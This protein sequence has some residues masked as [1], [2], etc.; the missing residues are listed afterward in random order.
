MPTVFLGVLHH[1]RFDKFLNSLKQYALELRKK[2]PFQIHQSSLSFHNYDPDAILFNNCAVARLV[3]SIPNDEEVL[4]VEL[5][6][7]FTGIKKGQRDNPLSTP[8]KITDRFTWDEATKNFLGVMPTPGQPIVM[9]LMRHGIGTHNVGNVFTKHFTRDPFLHTTLGI[10]DAAQII[11]QDVFFQNVKTL[12]L[13]SSPLRRAIQ[14]LYAVIDEITKTKDQEWS[15]ET[16]SDRICILPCLR[17]LDS[18]NSSQVRLGHIAVENWSVLNSWEHTDFDSVFY[19]TMIENHYT[20]DKTHFRELLDLETKSIIMDWSLAQD[21]CREGQTFLNFL[22]DV[23]LQGSQLYEQP[24]D[25]QRDAPQRTKM[26]MLIEQYTECALRIIDINNGLLQNFIRESSL[27]HN[28]W[29][30]TAEGRR[31]SI[32]GIQRIIT[33]FTKR[34]SSTGWTT[35]STGDEKILHDLWQIERRSTIFWLNLLGASVIFPEHAQTDLPYRLTWNGSTQNLTG[36]WR[37]G[38][39]HPD[40]NGIQ[41]QVSDNQ[42]TPSFVLASG[43]S[44]S[45]K[46]FFAKIIVDQIILRPMVVVDGSLSRAHSLVYQ[47]TKIVMDAAVVNMN[48]TVKNDI[49]KSVVK[50]LGFG[51]FDSDKIKHHFMEFLQGKLRQGISIYIPD[52]LSSTESL[53]FVEELH[54]LSRADP[55]H[56]YQILIFQHLTPQQC[57]FFNTDYVCKGTEPSGRARQKQQSKKYSSLGYSKSISLGIDTL[58]PPSKRT[59]NRYPVFSPRSP[60]TQRSVT[61]LA[62]SPN[63]GRQST[64]DHRI[65]IHNAGRPGGKSIG[66]YLD[67]SRI[68]R[69]PFTGQYIQWKCC[70]EI[71]QFI[72]TVKTLTNARSDSPS[73]TLGKLVRQIGIVLSSSS[74]ASGT[75]DQTLPHPQFQEERSETLNVVSTGFMIVSAIILAG[76]TI[77]RPSI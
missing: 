23:I 76:A 5:E 2:N 14:T 32:Y 57:P 61:R 64:Y 74:G 71:Q 53:H 49:L 48:V 11:R 37:Y 65:C 17:E 45:G 63:F 62:E 31:T 66:V 20:E 6:M 67:I 69:Q 77:L 72:D 19:D 52:T 36:V 44:A 59:D 3:L 55:A 28:I 75:P 29:F 15:L 1:A 60:S 30:M 18:K 21:E 47:T 9:Y 46:T 22:K 38:D 58:S 35:L 33:H 54:N 42:N 8:N 43:P 51:E 50:S 73:D 25:Q 39:K 13:I 10:K 34:E 16:I 56:S 70:T 27:R 68:C 40:E 41:I 24:V 26:K 12:Y 7:L 4:S